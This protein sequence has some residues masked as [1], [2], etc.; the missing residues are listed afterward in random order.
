MG[1]VRKVDA[2]KRR[3]LRRADADRRAGV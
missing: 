3:V 1:Q 2:P